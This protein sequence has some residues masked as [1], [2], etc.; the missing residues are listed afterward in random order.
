[1]LAPALGRYYPGG[2]MLH[3]AEG[4]AK[5]AATLLAAAAAVALNSLV[6]VLVGG[7]VVAGVAVGAG[8]PLE[9]LVRSLRPLLY[10]LVFTVGVHALFTGEPYLVGGGAF[11]ISQ[12]GLETGLFVSA[13]LLVVM[14]ATVILALTTT[15]VEL[16]AALTRL[17]SPLARI[18]LPTREVA[19]I[20]SLALRF[21]PSLVAEADRIRRA[22]L[23]R[24]ARWD[25][26]GPWHRARLLLTLLVPLF[27]QVYRRSRE[28]AE[29]M[30]VRGFSSGAPRS[31][32]RDRPLGARDWLLIAAAAAL[33]ALSIATR[34]L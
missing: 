1:M 21:L 3:R 30:D 25:A 34:V 28:V 7:A 6:A 29:A 22:Q 18:G 5:L 24:G 27:V 26:G 20:V 17:S 10:V 9:R 8:I 11:G 13:R 2:S 4:R 31:S 19:A 23:M 16:T 15:P 14:G 33:L 32:W 12:Q